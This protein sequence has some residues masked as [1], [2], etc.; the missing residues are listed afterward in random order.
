M[1]RLITLFRPM[2]NTVLNFLR[3]VSAMAAILLAMAGSPVANAYTPTD[4][5]VK[6][7]IDG[8]IAYLEKENGDAAFGS[9][10][11]PELILAAY[12]HYKVR[13]DESHPVIQNGLKHA[14]YFISQIDGKNRPQQSSGNYIYTVAALLM[15]EL[16][17]VGFKAECERI[18]GSLLAGQASH[19]GFTYPGQKDGDVSQTQYVALAI[20]T[21]DRTGIPLNYQSVA[22]TG[23]FI[24]RVQDITGTWPYTAEIPPPGRGLI[25]QET[26]SYSM[27][28]AGGSALLIVGDALRLWGET[29]NEADPEID[30]LPEA[31][32]LFKEDK[33]KKRRGKSQ[34]NR[35]LVMGAIGRLE[36]W[37]KAN[38]F[39]RGNAKDHFYYILYSRERY[40]SFVEIAR[41]LNKDSSPSWYNE[42]VD[43]LKK[44]QTPEGGWVDTKSKD[45]SRVNT[46][47]AIL[48]LIRSTQ[49]A[50]FKIG[51]AS[52]VGGYRLPTDTTQDLNVEG[53]QIK[54]QAIQMQVTDLLSILSED[55]SAS[56]QSVGLPDDI[57]FSNDPEERDI[58][59]ER[60]ERLL[61]GSTSYKAR[62]IA[63]KVLGKT[64]EL[65]VAPA[66]IFALSDRDPVVNRYAR[67]G[68]R[69][70]SR[71]FDGYEMPEMPSRDADAQE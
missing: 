55:D 45:S 54:G 7:M 68:L 9:R 22:K 8:G 6:K 24:M 67:D 35:D 50:I 62:R 2:R 41:G 60:F 4:P 61:R 38:P 49:K 43:K 47:F 71:K 63:A 25:R 64:D 53:G 51:S 52:T 70:I 18:A 37:L 11:S 58:Q 56:D 57:D 28:L 17:P 1:V 42:Y 12:A 69:F 23:E 33:N 39:V 34:L 66:L 40:E 19:G 27:A 48:F 44:L 59:I 46:A 20:W 30:G 32:Q 26:T 65:R 13:H 16:D 31:V 10:G 5:A 15:A 14:R 21:L 36:N 29:V 3:F